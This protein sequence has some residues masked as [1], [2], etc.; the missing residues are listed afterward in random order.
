[1]YRFGTECRDEAAIE[2]VGCQTMSIIQS[3]SE[4]DNKF[5]GYEQDFLSKSYPRLAN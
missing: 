4:T 2:K 5:C 1:M 3:C